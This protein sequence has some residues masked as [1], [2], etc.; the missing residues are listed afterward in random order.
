L[1]GF[2]LKRR[3]TSAIEKLRFLASVQK[4]DNPGHRMDIYESRKE[5]PCGE[6]FC[7]LME[8]CFYGIK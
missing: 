5:I 8:I 3:D 4:S 2:W 6:G 7:Q 1:E